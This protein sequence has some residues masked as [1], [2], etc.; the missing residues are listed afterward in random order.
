MFSFLLN[1]A[2]KDAIKVATG[3]D[4]SAIS[5]SDISVIEE[6][7]ERRT[8]TTLE[9]AISIG[10][11]QPRGSVY[12]MLHRFFTAKEVDARLEKIKP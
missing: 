12:L 8:N 7:I 4:A 9:E 5:G 11:L 6:T 1:K 10:G 2:T 3:L